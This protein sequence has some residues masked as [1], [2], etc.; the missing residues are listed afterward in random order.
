MKKLCVNIALI[1]V[2]VVLGLVL[3]FV[4]RSFYRAAYPMEYEQI[5]FAQ[6]A[7]YGVP[8][9]L[10]FAVI[11]TESGF[12]P[13]ATSHVEARGLMQITEDTF[14][15]AQYRIGEA[16]LSF[17]DLYE[18]QLN[19][20]YGTVILSLLLEEFG[21]ERAALA[22]YHA[23]WGRAKEWLDDA[24]Y[25]QDGVTLAHIPSQVTDGYVGK[26]LRTQDAYRKL[27]GFA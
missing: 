9:E 19:I 24:R 7:A 16:D 25:S 3:A 18:P 4:Q 15:W 2:I 21:N 27:Y 17:D 12:D 13:Q 26:V 11:H 1:A 6:S 5:V 10:V 14:E 20:R 23:G 8:P 22:A